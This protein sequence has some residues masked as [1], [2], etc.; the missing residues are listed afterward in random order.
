MTLQE[1]ITQDLKTAMVNR[2]TFKRDFLRII[3]SEM[4]Y[5]GKV[6][7]DS[8]VIRVLKRLKTNAILM[9]NEQE[10]DIIKEYE[11]T[12]LS[13]DEI[14]NIVTTIIS[15]KGYTNLRDLGGVMVA[16]KSH[17]NANQIDAKIASE[18]AKKILT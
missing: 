7:P 13:V 2:D 12:K 16:I 10:V 4:N 5:I 17:E 18:I 1:R 15:T 3:I 6:L 14:N 11:P 9:K 8:E